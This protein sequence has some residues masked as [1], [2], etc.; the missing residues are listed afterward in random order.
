MHSPK[1]TKRISVAYNRSGMSRGRNIWPE[2]LLPSAT[3]SDACIAGTK[4]KG[5]PLFIIH[6]AN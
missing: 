4:Y 5:T 3:N 2:N 6:E 1:H